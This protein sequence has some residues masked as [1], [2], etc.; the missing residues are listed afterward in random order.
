MA[1]Q[2][3]TIGCIAG[4]Q[5]MEIHYRP[6]GWIASPSVLMFC[7]TP[8]VVIAVSLGLTLSDPSILLGHVALALGTFAALWILSGRPLIDPIQAMVFLF[9]WWFA[10][11]PAVCA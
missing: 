8:L 2:Q 6:A 11:G 4:P 1:T 3:S 5:L 10:V 7:F 9:H